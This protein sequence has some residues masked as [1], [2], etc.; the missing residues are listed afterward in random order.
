MIVCNSGKKQLKFSNSS[1]LIVTTKN[2][3]KCIVFEFSKSTQFNHAMNRF[4]N[5]KTKKNLD[6]LA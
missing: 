2:H 4:F 5:G 6:R 1:L 3:F